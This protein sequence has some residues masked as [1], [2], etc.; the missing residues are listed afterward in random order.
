MKLTLSVRVFLL[1][2]VLFPGPG[3]ASEPTI[4]PEIGRIIAEEGI[5]AA[6]ARFSEMVNDPS[7]D[8]TMEIQGLTTLATAYI[9]ANNIEAATAVGNMTQQL[10]MA[11]MS[12][13]SM[14]QQPGMTA[15]MDAYKQGE[16]AAAAQDAA[17]KKEQLKLE[18]RR[19]AQEQGKSRDDLDRFKGLYAPKGGDP[20]KALFVT[21]SCD[22]YLVTGPMWADVGPWWM[23]SAADHV[24]TYSDSWTDLS[25]E[26]TAGPDGKITGLKHD[27]DGLG[28]PADRSGDLPAD[29][30]ACQERLRR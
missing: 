22:G 11:M 23:R 27:V 15:Q 20:N 4:A 29:W 8:V 28:S 30:P 26:F 24:F 5:E 9:Q 6:N 10:T 1:F 3:L 25:M 16:E 19:L 7:L 12:G 14:Q 17:E 18:Q 13:I 2:T 21:I